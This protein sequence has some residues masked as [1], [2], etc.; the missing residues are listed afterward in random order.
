MQKKQPPI[1]KRLFNVR[2][3]IRTLDLLVRSQTLYPAE[4]HAH[5]TAITSSLKTYKRFHEFLSDFYILHHQTLS[6]NRFLYDHGNLKMRFPPL[7][8]FYFLTRFS[9]YQPA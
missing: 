7:H 2:E 1:F 4:L 9:L 6:V 3:R 8:T 5:H